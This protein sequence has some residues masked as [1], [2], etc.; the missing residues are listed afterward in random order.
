VSGVVAVGVTIVVLALANVVHAAPGYRS[1]STA[2]WQNCTHVHARYEH[3]LGRASA[4]DHTRSG[5]N[6]VTSFYRS[7][8]LYNLATSHNHRLDADHDGVACEAH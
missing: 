8:R 4:H 3:G 7:T 6:P 5:A 2:W 1:G